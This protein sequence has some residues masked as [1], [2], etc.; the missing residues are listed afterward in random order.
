MI[1]QIVYFDGQHKF[2][3]K[4]NLLLRKQNRSCFFIIPR[5][6]TVS[7]H[8]VRFYKFLRLFIQTSIPAFANVKV[9]SS[10]FN[11]NVNVSC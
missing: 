3:F 4:L 2:L 6:N 1:S 8:I 5:L 7:G 11:F 10:I 9:A